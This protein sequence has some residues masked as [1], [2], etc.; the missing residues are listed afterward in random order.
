[1]KLPHLTIYTDSLPPN[2]NG[3]TNA[4]V[5]RIRSACKD[6]IGVHNHEYQH[7]KQWYKVLAVWLSLSALLVVGTYESLGYA[8]V[9]VAIGGIGLHGLLYMLVRSYRLKA[10]SQAY[11]A[12][13]EA[14][15]NLDTMADDLADASY[16]LGIT[17]EQA[18]EEIQRWITHG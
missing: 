13:V 18:K 5:V 1:M 15:A 4:F 9:P 11:A 17:K 7:V 3:R 16:K 2:I 8:L 14:G 6:D 10:E 12:Q